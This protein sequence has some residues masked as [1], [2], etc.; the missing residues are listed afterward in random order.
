MY[1]SKLEKIGVS[2]KSDNI[3]DALHEDVRTLLII[4]RGIPRRMRNVSDEIYR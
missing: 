4:A 3:T 2:L 1:F